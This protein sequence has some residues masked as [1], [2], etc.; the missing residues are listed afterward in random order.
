MTITTIGTTGTAPAEAPLRPADFALS[1]MRVTL[2]QECT[3][4][5]ETLAEHLGTD[6]QDDPLQQQLSECVAICELFIGAN[7]RGSRYRVR[8][9]VMCAEVCRETARMCRESRYAISRECQVACLACAKLVEKDFM[10]VLS[11]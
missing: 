3:E 2:L 4:A 6:V 1:F 10:A 5:C 11:N 8:Y 9:G 7:V